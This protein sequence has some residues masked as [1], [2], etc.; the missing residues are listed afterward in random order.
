MCGQSA[1]KFEIADVHESAHT[2]NPFMKGPAVRGGFYEIRTATMVDLISNAYGVDGDKV[3]GGPSWLEMERFDITAKAPPGLKRNELK[4]LLKA[5]LQE[6]FKLVVHEDTRPIPAYALTAGKHPSL[7]KSEGAGDT[8]CKMGQPQPGSAPVFAH[9]CSNVTMAAF[10]DALK[11][12]PA[13]FFYLDQQSIVDRTELK[14]GWDFN[15]K[16]TFRNGIGQQEETITVFDAIEKLGLKLEP[17]KVP[18][19][20]IVV[21]AVNQKPTA[22]AANLAESLH[23]PPAPTEFEVAEVKPNASSD[24][25]RMFRIQRGGRVTLTGMNLRS[26]IQEAWN[27]SED[28]LAGAPKWIDEDRFDIV[29]KAPA[30]ESSDV[31]FDAILVMMRA[32]LKERF[33][34]AVHMEDRQVNAYTLTAGKPKMK[35]ADPASRTLFKEGPAPDSKDP[36]NANPAL[37]RLVTVQNMTMAQF[38]AQL[39]DIAPGYIKVPVLDATGLEGSWDF[40]VNFSPA[41]LFQAGRGGGARGGDAAAAPSG[42]ASEP[43]GGLTL[44][45]AIEKQLGLKLVLQKRTVPVLVVDHVEQKPTDN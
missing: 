36:R 40:T 24:N 10:A 38:A 3:V 28:M 7:K 41:G 17:A 35:K 23:A 8:G 42:E 32:L 9:T 5:L 14:G 45:E 39:Q 4:P 26:L 43:T 16:Y 15:L 37:S 25:R 20:V 29:A 22:N 12:M 19:Q 31:D 27:V 13:G 30:E 6:R 44:P 18:M 33:K 1:D 2:R 34:L 21:D 11:N